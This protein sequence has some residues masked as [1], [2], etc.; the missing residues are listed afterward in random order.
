MAAAAPSGNRE[1]LIK[2]LLKRY[3]N[4]LKD[5]LTDNIII[6]Q[7]DVILQQID[8]VEHLSKLHEPIN[9]LLTKLDD[10]NNIDFHKQQLRQIS[11]EID[12]LSQT[13]GGKR[14]SR[15]SRKSRKTRKTC[16]T[17]K[18]RKSCK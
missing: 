4:L 1:V 8:T 3:L 11:R 17:R 5:D 15:K 6:Q 12:G 16:K 10:I 14:K 13:R 2:R 7:I 18:T 9:S